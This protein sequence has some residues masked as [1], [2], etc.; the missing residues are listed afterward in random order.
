ME[1]GLY[2]ALVGGII[3]ALVRRNRK[4]VLVGSTI[5]LVIYVALSYQFSLYLV[6]VMA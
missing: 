2:F 1:T 3:G 6:R 4:S 5:G